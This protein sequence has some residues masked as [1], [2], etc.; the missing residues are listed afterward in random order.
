M[1]LRILVVGAG[2]IGG[3]FGVRLAKAGRNV[4]FLVRPKRAETLRETGLV[5]EAPDGAIRLDPN[6]ITAAELQTPF[7]VILLAVKAFALDAALEDFAPAVGHET[8]ILP[9]LNGLAH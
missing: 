7:D 1:S 2:A 3:L 5:L 4:S 9:L 8:M 6:L